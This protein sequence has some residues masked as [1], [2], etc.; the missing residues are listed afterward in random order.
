MVSD[1]NLFMVY[2]FSVQTSP[3]S[4]G[5]FLLLQKLFSAQS[6]EEVKNVALQQGFT[7]EELQVWYI[8]VKQLF[9]V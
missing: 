2:Y 9:N 8:T 6:V 1:F 4:P 5:I 7:D 3:E